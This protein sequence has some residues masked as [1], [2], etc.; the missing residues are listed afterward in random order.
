MGGLVGFTNSTV[1]NSY[2]DVAVSNSGSGGAAGG[3][4][5]Y[6]RGDCLRGCD[7]VIDNSFAVG[8][9]M[10]GDDSSAGGLVGYSFGGIITNSYAVGAV[11]VGNSGSVGG[12]I[13]INTD[14]TDVHTG[15]VV[16]FSYATG[17]VTGGSGATVGGL[18]GQ[19]VPDS[20]NTNSDWDMDTSGISDPS[21]GAGNIA[22]DPGIT[23][24]T[25]AQFKSGL[26]A[27]FDKKVWKQKGS[28]N[29]GYP[30]L[31]DNPPPQ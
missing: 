5:G 21:Q 30:Y 24:L 20:Q 8:L 23:G 12:M 2:A 4:V 9:V 11:S 14:N 13:G 6:L 31:A 10:A 15:P 1:M 27:G 7:G 17:L 16:L 28:V 25:D 26:P 3:L 29:Y 18:I 19:D 22:N